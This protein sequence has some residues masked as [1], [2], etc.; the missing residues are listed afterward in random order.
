MSL[1]ALPS[2]F[3]GGPKHG[4]TITLP[5]VRASRYF[6]VEIDPIAFYIRP[7][8]FPIKPLTIE[9]D[10]YRLIVAKIAYEYV[11]RF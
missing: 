10:E 9:Q 11:G 2:Y 8:E 7:D 5:D 4:Q 3:T 1:L 6:P